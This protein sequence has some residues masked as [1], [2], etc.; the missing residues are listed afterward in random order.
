M[1]KSTRQFGLWDSPISAR[2]TAGL[3]RF[4]DIA[5]SGDGETL[6]WVEGRGARGVVVCRRGGNAPRD[7]SGDVSV[8]GG[9]GYGGGEL[10]V[11][12]STAFFS[13]SDGRLYR[14]ELGYGSPR[15]ITPPFGKVASPTVS[16]DGRWVAFVHTDGKTDVL[17]AVD[18]E[19]RQWPWKVVIGSD[20]YM[21]PAWSSDGRR[22]AWISWDH[23]NMPWDGTRLE[24]AK[25]EY[26]ARGF[27]LGEIEVWA[28]GPEKAVQQ[29]TFSPDGK[30]LAY[31]SDEL[32]HLHLWL[33]D[34][35]TGESR[36]LSRGECD[37][38][39]PA[40][41]QGLRSFAWNAQSTTL[42]AVRNER[43]VLSLVRFTLDGA[44]NPVGEAAAYTYVGQPAV[45][46]SGNVAFIGSSSVTPP[47]I[48]TLMNSDGSR[49]EQR[50]SNE[51]VSPE[52]HA[53]MSPVS[54]T[55]ARDGDGREIEVFGN[56]YAPASEKFEGTGKPPAIIRIHGGPTSQRVASYDAQCQFFATRGFAV[57]DVNYRG[58]TGYG[59]DYME[60]LRGQWGVA[61][62]EDALGG[63]RFLTETGL[64][65]PQKLVI[66]GG[67]AGGYTVLQ[68]LTDHPG[69]F[70]AG[71]CLY[72][73]A[74]LFTL[75]SG[76]HKFESRYNDRLL[77]VLP[78]AAALFRERSP[79]FKADRIKDP[80]AI[81]HGGEDKVVPPD[82]AE[83]I[84]ASLAARGIP[85]EY[86]LY[87]DEGHGFRRP[88]N[89][90]HFY[91]S[92]LQF[93]E[94]HVLVA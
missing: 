10:C 49:V 39:G 79:L 42:T 93:L 34:L 55:F 58:S 60:L 12:G 74:N 63:A 28:G 14:S 40:W 30:W 7:V 45:S 32:G 73:I 5:W 29:P 83:S 19:G 15:P 16:P 43:G 65:D 89:L 53:A 37:I 25:V 54:W 1:T 67:S 46:P 9:V 59:R 64:A 36:P 92:L 77:G 27:R 4:N 56:Y 85:H 84:V 86:H 23:P 80:V 44:N 88:E 35:E 41:V 81:Y 18:A 69:T 94:Q 33:Q 38:G 20:F 13:G 21:Q 2:D 50:A 24:T 82:Q 11:H 51:R 76:T 57:L 72:G 61:D 52:S 90:E 68:A 47:R 22:L 78:E 71:V 17:A 31:T 8:R 87:D 91:E 26:D 62:V 70:K 3:L 75:T 48:V 66:M 6:V